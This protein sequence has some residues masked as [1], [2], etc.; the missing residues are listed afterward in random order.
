MYFFINEQDNSVNTYSPDPIPEFMFHEGL[1][2]VE[3]PVDHLPE[4]TDLFLA[5]YDPV[6]ESI[7]PNKMGLVPL[8]KQEFTEYIEQQKAIHQAITSAETDKFAKLV[9][10]LAEMFPGNE[11]I[12]QILSDNTV[13]QDELQQI[14]NMLNAK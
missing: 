4:G 2:K 1:Y 6:T 9:G 11:T 3:K 5:F 7:I 14:E 8:S 13:T 10:F 12:K